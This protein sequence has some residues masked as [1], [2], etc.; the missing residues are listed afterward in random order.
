MSPEMEGFLAG[1]DAV[2][3]DKNL[4]GGGLLAELHAEWYFAETGID[5][6][7]EF[8]EYESRRME[9]LDE[10]YQVVRLEDD[11][12]RYRQMAKDCQVL[13]RYR[14]LIEREEYRNLPNLAF[15]QAIGPGPNS[16]VRDVP[17]DNEPKGISE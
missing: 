12:R 13:N 9:Q 4:H 1:D 14:I 8:S 11:H 16:I 7:F 17:Q 3:R 5:G 6:P 10:H 2:L 15:T